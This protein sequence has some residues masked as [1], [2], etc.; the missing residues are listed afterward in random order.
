[1]SNVGISLCFCDSHCCSHYRTGAKKTDSYAAR[2]EGKICCNVC[3]YKLYCCSFLY[4][5]SHFLKIHISGL[6]YIQLFCETRTERSVEVYMVEKGPPPCPP[7]PTDVTDILGIIRH[8]R[9]RH[10]K[11][12]LS[13]T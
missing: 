2:Y 10:V 5:H 13:Q 4:G 9:D 6:V 3:T 7:P 1:M 12:G 11:K 8:K